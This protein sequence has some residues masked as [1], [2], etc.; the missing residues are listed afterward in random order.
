M[1]VADP[2]ARI[3]G[4]ASAAVGRLPL[5]RAIALGGIVVVLGAFL[6]VLH[7]ISVITG[8]PTPLYYAVVGSVVVGTV[9]A[10]VIRPRT[11]TVVSVAAGTVG[12]YLYIRSLPG[13][14]SFLVL[15]EPILDDITALL[16][17]LSVLRIV[18]A[19]VWAL[20]IA[21]GPVFLTWYLAVRR[22]YVAASVVGGVALGLVVLTGDATNGE[23]FVGVVGVA[24]AVA[25]GDCERR[26]ERFGN[27]D[28]VAVAV[29]AMVTLTLFVGVVPGAIGAVL[30]ESDFGESGSTIESSLVYAGDSVAVTG[31]VE[32]TSERR[33]T[34]EADEPA[35]W[36]VGTYDRYTG[37]GWVRSGSSSGYDGRLPGPPGDT[38]RLEQEY[39]AESTIATL[40]AAREPI[41]IDGVPVPVQV[42][43]GGSFEPTST[44]QAGESYTVESEIPVASADELR[45]AGT[46]YPDDVESRYTQLPTDMPDRVTQRTDQL[47]A[48]AENPYDTARVLEYWFRT[49]YEYSLDVDRPRGDIADAFLF[50]MAA[51]YCTYFA[52][53]MTAMLRTQGIPA[54]MAVG[55][56][57]GEQVGDDEWVV[58]G[59]DSHA[60]V[61]VYFPEHGWIEFDP[62][63]SEPRE[64]AAQQVRDGSESAGAGSGLSADGTTNGTETDPESGTETPEQTGT[65][66]PAAGGEEP[67]A[68][69]ADGPDIGD[70]E[71]DADGESTSP[72][73][74]VPLPS[75]EQLGFG[76]GVAILALVGARRSGVVTRLYREWW[77]RRLPK[78]SPEAVVAGAYRRAVYLESRDGRAK[79]PG[80]TPR[81]FFAD[82]DERLRR[83]ERA[84]ERARYG[85]GVDETAAARVRVDLDAVRA[86][87]SKLAGRLRKPGRGSR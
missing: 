14:G 59:Y 51:G 11:A 64:E 43:P 77:L 29:A 58:R 61:E 41:R 79:P 35:Y 21:P 17:G 46:D 76:L 84:Y 66:T 7:R 57:P 60:W 55:Y 48:N 86:D 26:G 56:T 22:R 67:T 2:R 72:L 50:E 68:T 23:T 45:N 12:T 40:P 33:Y 3:V 81:Q 75:G 9:A 62:T 24:I 20:A 52:T 78:G 73:A 1:S 34:V 36:R 15:A 80:E 10:R 83:I 65:E 37:G 85:P 71:A 74:S 4:G 30:P 13:G 8:D 19:D 38:R 27:V 70:R 32:L 63:P 54:R 28:T 18:N 82:A 87:R 53:T 69:V 49:E 47:T 44:L 5:L 6:S 31:P 39:T 25:I 16:S 42:T